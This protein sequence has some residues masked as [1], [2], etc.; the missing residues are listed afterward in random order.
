MPVIRPL[1]TGL[2]FVTVAAYG[3]WSWTG[4]LRWPDEPPY[5]YLVF[6]LLLPLAYLV[7]K[8]ASH[9]A[10]TRSFEFFLYMAMVVRLF[11]QVKNQRTREIRARRWETPG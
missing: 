11:T 1:W 3:V 5:N 7:T 4:L 2:A 8:L 6:A 10:E 9:Y